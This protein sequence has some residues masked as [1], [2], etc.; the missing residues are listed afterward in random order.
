MNIVFDVDGTICF[1]GQYIKDELS[2]QITALQH[3]HNI[4][5]A[6]ARPIR[7]LI[8]VVK[9]FNSQLLIG[10]NGS[11]VQNDDEIEVV[12]SIDKVSF[13]II[14]D[15]IYQYHLKYIVDDDFNMLLICRLIIKY[16]SNWIQTISQRILN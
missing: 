16:I 15:L 5:F 4:I 7:D 11:I 12:Q 13:K 6:S 8:P 2:N 10:G 1:N 3:K 14:Q 9:K